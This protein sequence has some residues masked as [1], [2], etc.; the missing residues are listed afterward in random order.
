MALKLPIYGSYY[1]FQYDSQ[2]I[3]IYVHQLNCNV[4]IANIGTARK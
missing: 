1:F 4:L 2:E 3:I